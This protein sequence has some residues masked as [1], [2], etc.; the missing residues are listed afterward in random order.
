M[1]IAAAEA[2]LKRAVSVARVDCIVDNNVVVLELKVREL[3]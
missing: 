3:F 2:R 1:L